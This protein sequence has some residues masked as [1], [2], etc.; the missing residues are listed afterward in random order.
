[1]HILITSQ[2]NGSGGFTYTFYFIGLQKYTNR[3][4][5]LLVSLSAD[6]TSDEKRNV[7]TKSLKS[8]IM[9]Y[10]IHTPV[11]KNLNIEYDAPSEKEDIII[12]KWNYWVF[13][14]SFNGYINGDENYSYLYLYSWISA[15]KITDEWKFSFSAGNNLSQNIYE[16]DDEKIKAL[17]TSY[18]EQNKIVKTLNN[19]FSAGII[20]K[21]TNSSY[22][23]YKTLMSAF[24]AIEF[25]IFPYSESNRKLLTAMY[26]TGY[27]Y[28]NYYDTTIYNKISENLI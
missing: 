25:N 27:S 7:F 17:S 5:T 11:Y 23:N 21:Y 22:N 2:L 4:D 10:V 24:P 1:L 20:L 26:S 16:Y 8:G 28:V 6:V 15:S 14:L 19:H 9:Q 13:D 3:N 18:Y 12:D